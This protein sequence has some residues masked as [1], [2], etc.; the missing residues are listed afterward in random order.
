MT[1][2]EGEEFAIA[3]GMRYFETSAATGDAVTDAMHYL[4][5]Q[6]V[7]LGPGV[8]SVFFSFFNLSLANR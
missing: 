6:A 7:L 4:F 1:R 2:A 8:G 3:H 5:E